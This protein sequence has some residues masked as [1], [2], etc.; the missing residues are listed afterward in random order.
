M[1]ALDSLELLPEPDDPRMMTTVDKDAPGY[2]L[3]LIHI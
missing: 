2:P 1:A 3:S